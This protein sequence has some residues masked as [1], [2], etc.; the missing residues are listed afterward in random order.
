MSARATMPAAYD[1]LMAGMLREVAGDPAVSPGTIAGFWPMVGHAY[2]GRLMVVG[3]A[4]NGWIDQLTLEALRSPQGPEAAAARMRRTAEGDGP[5]PMGWVCSMW[6]NPGG[7]STARSAFWRFVRRA[8]A[9]LDPDSIH[10]PWW[11]NRL[12]WSNLAKLAPWGG[13]NPGGALLDI[14]RRHG[15]GLLAAEVAALRPEVVLVLA[16]RWWSEPF[17]DRLALDVTWR[18][19]MLEGTGYD[20]VRRW[21]IGPHPQGKPRALWDEVSTVL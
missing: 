13:G 14:Q 7:Y 12:A 20:G 21:V 6:G 4:V 11:S 16:G 2:R 19:G 18:E 15:P 17:V 3:R 9:H 5:S 1:G 8:L 10:D